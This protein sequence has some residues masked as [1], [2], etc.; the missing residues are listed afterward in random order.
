MLKVIKFSATWCGPCRALQP[1]WDQLVDDIND[2]EFEAVDID[3][4][5]ELATKYSV[6]AVPTM[7]FVKGGTVVETLVGL[8]SAAEIKEVIEKHKG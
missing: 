2:V 5:G 4:S 7:V 3:T 8:R 6:R 1:I